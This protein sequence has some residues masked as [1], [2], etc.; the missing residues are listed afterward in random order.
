MGG[1]EAHSLP[2]VLGQVEQAEEVSHVLQAKASQA[3]GMVWS[4]CRRDVE[5]YGVYCG[6]FEK[7]VFDN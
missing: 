7:V 1:G 2:T 6:R 4:E 5:H 3:W